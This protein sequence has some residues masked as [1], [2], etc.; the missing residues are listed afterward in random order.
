[1]G[2]RPFFMHTICKIFYFLHTSVGFYINPAYKTV[3][4]EQKQDRHAV[5][6]RTVPEKGEDRYV[7]E[8]YRAHRP[9]EQ[10]HEDGA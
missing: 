8:D 4:R 2:F 5:C 9:W 6:L 7:S 10:E 3:N 1:M